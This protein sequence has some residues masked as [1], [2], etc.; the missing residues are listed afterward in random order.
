MRFLIFL[1][2]NLLIYP[3]LFFFITFLSLFSKKIRYGYIGRFRTNEVLKNYF[4][5]NIINP[6]I[7][8]FHCS[9][10]GEY[11]QVDPIINGIKKK[12]FDCIIIVSFFSPS[13]INNVKNKNVDCKVY[14]PFDFYWS[15]NK[16]FNIIKP[17]IIIFSSADL[18]Y[19][20]IYIA[21]NKNI[22]MILINAKSKNYFE[23]KLNLFHHIYR[24][25]YQSVTKIY[26]I[27]KNDFDS[28]DRYIGSDKIYHL[29]NPRYDQVFLASNNM[30]EEN[31]MPIDQ[32]KNILF[33]ASMHYEDRNVIL[34][35]LVQY[36]KKN[37]NLEVFWISHEPASQENKYLESIFSRQGIS[38]EVINSQEKLNN[39]TN[40]VKIINI[41]G[42][43]A[44]LYWHAKIAY[45]GGGF[46]TGVH[47]LMEPA[48]AGVP[49]FF[50]PNY[51]SFDE[52]VQIINNEAGF[53][54]NK[55][56]DFI[57]KMDSLLNKQDKIKLA[58][59]QAF[60]II[61]NN[62]GSS[63]KLVEDIIS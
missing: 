24:S 45:I 15:V 41:V 22:D 61:K 34:P 8:W 52:A 12:K 44:E 39:C 42:V 28:Y 54:V 2:Y 48:V 32:R 40:R 49:T 63:D 35:G 27:N 3:I 33:L 4:N 11:L 37:D 25:I 36:L 23:N 46:S 19:N 58:S 5:K 53:V 29:G 30:P 6:N 7:Y 47:N 13:G 21:K 10:F 18:W 9:S 1:F 51:Q 14:I 26:T 60:K 17:K 50:G 31:K 43:L 62:I 55:G 20:F 57:D 56:R 59:S 38:S 16:T